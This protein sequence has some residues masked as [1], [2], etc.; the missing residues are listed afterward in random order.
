MGGKIETALDSIL[1]AREA[2]GQKQIEEKKSRD[3]Q[4][5]EE[6]LLKE[7]AA[8][9]LFSKCEQ[10]IDESPCRELF[11]EANNSYLNGKGSISLERIEE[12]GGRFNHPYYI[13]DRSRNQTMLPPGAML[14]LRG[15]RKGKQFEL[16][17]LAMKARRGWTADFFGL[18]IRCF[19][20]K[21]SPLDRFPI[22]RKKDVNVSYATLLGETEFDQSDEW[23][24]ENRVAERIASVLLGQDILR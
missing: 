22:K 13:N 5:K 9:E 1:K 6:G 8:N 20:R 24:D 11:E 10:M 12:G 16:Q 4:K 2:A 23:R 3:A 18:E 15:T 7:Q 21:Q 17:A 19:S 14:I